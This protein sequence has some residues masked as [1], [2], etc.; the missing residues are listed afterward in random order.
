M[1]DYARLQV[2]ARGRD[3]THAASDKTL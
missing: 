3:P 2:M 1:T